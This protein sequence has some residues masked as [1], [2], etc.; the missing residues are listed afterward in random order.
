MK[1]R[2]HVPVLIVTAFWAYVS[3][4]AILYA[5]SV[6]ELLGAL[7]VTDFLAPWK[8]Q[9]LQHILL[10][11]VLLGCAWVSRRIGW[12]PFARRFVLQTLLG[13]AFAGI[14]VPCLALAD[15][16]TGNLAGAPH[17]PVSSVGQ[18]IAVEA[19][20]LLSSV[21]RFLLSYAFAMALVTGFELYRKLRDSE[22][23]S[24]SLARELVTAR[25]ATLRMQLSPHSLFN[26]LHTIHGQIEWDPAAARALVI[27]FGDFLRRLLK[28]SEREF[29][30]LAEEIEFA[31]LYLEL[32]QKR[33]AD[34]LTVSVREEEA[35]AT[36]WV[37]SLILQPLVENAVMHGLT[38]HHGAVTVSVEAV[39]AGG[40]LT[41]RVINTMSGDGRCSA[42]GIGLKN[43]RDRLEIHFGAA[44]SV[45]AAPSRS[46]EWVGEI[47]LPRL[48]DLR[49]PSVS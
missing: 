27:R 16:I 41:L 38:G 9:A 8:A 4:S 25:L 2:M 6:Q 22:M 35:S 40:I 11:P 29:W 33:F 47:R 5:K 28:A 32:Q 19:P 18:A 15:A 10:Y 49:V 24:A 48:P 7:H 30:R 12:Q 13:L 39:S 37:P 46:G 31:R 26:L 42:A 17:V 21:M 36:V 45:R 34:R 3:A 44:A 23:H 1:S 43:V 14:A 20:A